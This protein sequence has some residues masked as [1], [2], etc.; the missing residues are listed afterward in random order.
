MIASRRLLDGVFGRHSPNKSEFIVIVGEGSAQMGLAGDDD[1]IEIFATDRSDKPLR[2]HADAVSV[3]QP[4]S[5]AICCVA[6]SR[7]RWIVYKLGAAIAWLR[8]CVGV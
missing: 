3:L 7:L 5:L 2:I 4:F 6:P 1:V 8:A